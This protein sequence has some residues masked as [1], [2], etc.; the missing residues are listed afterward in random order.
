MIHALTRAGITV[1]AA[2]ARAA[3]AE[4]RSSSVKLSEPETA[5]AGYLFGPDRT[6]TLVIAR[7]ATVV[8]YETHIGLAQVLVTLRH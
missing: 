4:S 6:S 5:L 3:V 7:S 1:T 8:D 2:D